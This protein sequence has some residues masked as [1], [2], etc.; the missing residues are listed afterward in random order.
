MSIDLPKSMKPPLYLPHW[1]R[2]RLSVMDRYIALEL[3]PPFL[4]GVGAF[5]SVGVAIGALF[6]LIRRVTE[7]ALP[8]STALQVFFLQLPYFISLAFPMSTLLASL[9]VYSRLSSDSEIIALRS[10]GVSLYRI[11]LPA[12]VVSFLVT[13]ITFWFNESIVPATRYQATV[14]MER[15][16]KQ[17]RPTFKENNILFQEFQDVRRASGEKER[18]LSRIF[19]ARQ[20]D[21]QRMRGLTILDFSREGLNQVVASES[22]IWNPQA[23]SWTF[24]NGT[25][26][27]VAP[28]G[29]Y[30]NILK[31]EQQQL[32]LP[33]TPLDLAKRE[34][35]S[36]EM[37]IAQIQDYMVLLQQSGDEKRLRRMELRIQQKL[38]FPFVCVVFGL[39]G[40]TLGTSPR[41]TGRATS[42][43]ISVVIIFTYYLLAFI[44][45]SLGQLEVLPIFMAAWL[46]T[47]AGLTVGSLLLFRAGR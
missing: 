45:D 20:F 25:I 40:A 15:A 16:L 29:S 1:F 36:E 37:N 17:D 42:F 21:G 22:A 5:A 26:Y 2:W 19:Y 4:F 41:R 6:D 11:V 33:R 18:V 27:L 7:A 31:F 23:N 10:A 14:T 24:F 46:P 3:I 43:G 35:A 8:L 9:M 13:G 47:I 32:R 44:C 38:A 28:D 39:V 34:P 30:R 12:V